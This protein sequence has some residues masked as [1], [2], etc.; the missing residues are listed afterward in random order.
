MSLL[1][2]KATRIFHSDNGVLR[3]I[4][5]QMKT[6]GDPAMAF[7][8]WVAAEDALYLGAIHKFNT[9]Y[10]HIPSATV[11]TKEVQ[12]LTFSAAPASG[13]FEIELDGQ[14]TQALP[15]NAT[16]GAIRNAINDLLNISGAGV[17]GSYASGIDVTFGDL[18]AGKDL[19]LMSVTH[20]LKDGS[21]VAITVTPSQ[22]T[23]GAA[24]AVP[25]GNSIL[26]AQYWNNSQWVDFDLF[27][28]E[29]NGFSRSGFVQWEERIEWIKRETES[30]PELSTLK[31]REYIDQHYWVKLTFLS[32]PSAFTLQAIKSL[33][34][35]D[36]SMEAIYPEIMQ[37]LPVGKTNFLEQHE[38]AKNY[39]VAHLIAKNVI[40][41][42]DQLKNLDQWA[43]PATYKAISL[44][45]DP[46][47][48]DER[49]AEVKKT[50]RANA[51][52]TMLGI[53]ASIDKDKNETL[54]L[55]E[56]EQGASSFMKR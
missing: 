21:A 55:H 24:E 32:N 35:D 41:Y 27:L 48:G 33:F 19:P 52:K 28:D 37:Y 54:E 44:I 18:D 30:I 45:L 26:K 38:L 42:E 13:Y 14:V 46:I 20:T 56:R 7:P 29:T 6:W 25:A 4:T 12:R 51:E 9:R 5:E 22:T 40:Q 47:P 36:R 8:S 10:I 34:S 16:L 15:Y 50:M 1:R 11:P 2:S 43:L 17:T 53:A 39:I 3:D 31:F 23:A 49:L